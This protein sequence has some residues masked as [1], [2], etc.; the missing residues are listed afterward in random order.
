MNRQRSRRSFV[1]ASAAGLAT[2]NLLQPMSA[3]AQRGT[4]ASSSDG[5][6]E[7][8]LYR[9]VVTWD[10][11]RLFIREDLSGPGSNFAGEWD[12]VTLGLHPELSTGLVIVR[13]EELPFDSLDELADAYPQDYW[14]E[15]LSPKFHPRDPKVTDDAYGFFYTEEDTQGTG[16][17][18]C[19]YLE[20]TPPAKPGGAWGT[21]DFMTNVT[22]HEF[23][24]DIMSA[25][26][27]A[28]EING[29]PA[30]QAWTY[31][32]VLD[33]FAEEV[34]AAGG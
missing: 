13:F 29:N 25:N 17:H 1:A 6:W 22:Y 8:T 31:E 11:S 9:D 7:S 3:I 19:G 30:F 2:L 20:F 32:E 27:D 33:A 28:L 26:G 24:F 16:A 4:A 5:L 23:D 34:A 18:Y 21:L 12:K 15:E 10:E 14:S